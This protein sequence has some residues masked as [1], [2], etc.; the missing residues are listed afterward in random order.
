M[1]SNGFKYV[2]LIDIQSDRIEGEFSVYRQS[3]G[4]NVFMGV[5]DVAAA[6]RKRLARFAV[7][8]LETIEVETSDEVMSVKVGLIKRMLKQLKSV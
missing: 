6:F 8:F 7:S 1:I 5:S 3:T 4:A 2:L